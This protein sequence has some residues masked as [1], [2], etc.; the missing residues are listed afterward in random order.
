MPN[1][2]V[3]FL[4]VWIISTSLIVPIIY[5]SNKIGY[6]DVPNHRS[7]HIRAVPLGGGL[8]L[9]SAI[10]AGIYLFIEPSVLFPDHP[11]FMLL[12][13]PIFI[14]GLIDDLP[15]WNVDYK[16][17]L[18]VEIGV[19]I[20][21][22][23][24]GYYLRLTVFTFFDQ[25]I[26]LVWIIGFTNAFNLLDNMNGLAALVATSIAASF[27]YSFYFLGQIQMAG[28][29]ICLIA[30]LSGFLLFNYPKARIFMG[31]GGSLFI[32]MLISILSINFNNNLVQMQG[33]SS[34]VSTMLCLAVPLCDTTLVILLRLRGHRP[35]YHADNSH[36]S[37]QMVRAGVSPPI[38]VLIIFLFS[39]I[40]CL[41]SLSELKII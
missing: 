11:R 14:L 28:F 16:I 27:S 33:D 7:S 25:M 13:L 29:G 38:T 20:L 31:D 24:N 10:F 9:A 26:S 12:F 23:A 32:G 6:L 40:C 19:A 17:K 37:H 5:I 35:V 18:I 30:A 15:Q 2:I 34:L 1:F 8:A 22:V 4:I 21:F 3:L 41:I 39:C 36:L